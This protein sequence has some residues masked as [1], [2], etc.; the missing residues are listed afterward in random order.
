M[1]QF[2]TTSRSER[3]R[4]FVHAYER[5]VRAGAAY[6]QGHWS[7]APDIAKEVFNFVYD[8]GSTKS[9]LTQLGLRETLEFTSTAKE[10]P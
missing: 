9:I 2:E 7:E 6:D 8:H 4:L 5:L 10:P 3:E 1:P